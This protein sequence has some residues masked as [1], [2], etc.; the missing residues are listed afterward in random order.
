MDQQKIFNETIKEI[1]TQFGKGSLIT[2]DKIVKDVDTI[3]TGSLN[4]NRALGINGYPRGRI[5][6][7]Y[8][9]ESSGKTTLALQ[10]I[11]QC[12][13]V[14]GKCAYID[15]EHSLDGKY[16]I[17]NGVDLTKL[18]LAKPDSGEQ[19]FAIMEALIK[20]GMIDLIVVDSVAALVPE[21][22]INNE[23]ENQTIGLHA[24]LMSKGLRIIQSYAS[25]FN[26]TIIFINQIREK[27]G[28]MFGD[29]KTTTGGWALKF[30]SSLRIEL[31]R[32]ELLKNGTTVVG[33]K[34][35][36]RIIKNK[37]A[38][39][40][41][42]TFLEIYFDRGFDNFIELIDIAIEKGIIA[43]KGSWFFFDNKQLAQGKESLINFLKSS[44]GSET[45][46]QI[47][48]LLK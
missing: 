22:E 30:F 6:E 2:F 19:S 29:N 13:K 32:S 34:T 28:I 9:N 17:S 46:S 25:K 47:Q 44:D 45:L 14:G 26:T 11:S 18:L 41:S 12:Q 48:K 16:C 40:L 36:A 27:I 23:Y 37:L 24:R 31:K 21:A 20:T 42:T 8:G 4:L 43:K 35:Q 5:I 15:A 33:I 39:P 10:A 1:E 7:I 3:D 38:P